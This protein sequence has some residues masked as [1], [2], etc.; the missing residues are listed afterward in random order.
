MR[1]LR[2]TRAMTLRELSL[3]SGISLSHL[4][5]IER[6]TV[7]A[8]I[9]KI[10]KIAD[11]LSVPVPWF[12]SRRPGNGPLE[13]NYVVRAEN[14]RNLN[15]LYCE[16][17]ETSGYTDWLV[18]STIGGE[19]HMGVSEY[20]AYPLDTDDRLFV[21]E[22]EQHVLILEGVLELRLEDEI[23][24]LREGDSYSIPGEIPHNLRNLSGAPARLVWANA[25]VIV[26][27]DVIMADGTRLSA[28][29]K[30]ADETAQDE[31][32]DGPSG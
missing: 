26:P 4:S 20:A 14:R 28:N 29:L 16:P 19:F 22:G 18:S 11:A 13:Q 27:K 30:T 6:G 2:K 25:P 24:F 10:Q 23:I 12:F 5:A 8:S 31:K 7:N 17:A 15:V 9:A 32:P 21:R 3:T 1:Q